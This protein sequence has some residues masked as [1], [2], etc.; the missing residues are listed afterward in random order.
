VRLIVAGGGTGGHLYPGIA[1][2]DEVRAAGGE[3]MFVGTTRGIEARVVPA[4]G[5]P[6]ELLEVSGIKRMGLVRTLQGLGRVPLALGRSLSIVR[7]WKPDVVLGVGGYASGPM[8][9]AAALARYPT[10]IQEQNSVPGFTN[11]TLGRFVRAVFTA[12]EAAGPFF[13]ARKVALVGNPVRRKFVES[14]RGPAAPSGS[15]LVVGGSQG[16]RAVNELVIGAAELLAARGALPPLV[17]QTGTAD[18]DRCLERYRA[19]GLAE[20]VSVRPFIEDMAGTLAGA[21]L[22]IGRAG[23]L[24]LAELAIVGRPAILIPLPTAA[25]DHQS[26]NAAEFA[27]AG[28]AV[29]LEQQQATGASLAELMSGLLGDE[30]RR[31]KMAA[32]MRT[33]GRPGA[34]GEVVQRL[35]ALSGPRARP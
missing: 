7:K 22:V 8:V 4:A 20:R 16:A 23:A 3:V 25:D 35:A 21:G 15:V 9:L 18:A 13:P 34:A 19:L 30:P 29:V 6:L 24:T 31:E 2:A 1:V 17:H 12:F 11:R 32:A 26:K 10:A 33:L 28:A 27:R 14:A 5:Y